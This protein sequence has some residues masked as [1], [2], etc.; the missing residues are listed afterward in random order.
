MLSEIFVR[1]V[2]EQNNVEV[3]SAKQLQEL[4]GIKE[5][6]GGDG[7]PE[8]TP[9]QRKEKATKQMEDLF[10][11]AMSYRYD[12]ALEEILQAGGNYRQLLGLKPEY[13]NLPE[14]REIRWEYNTYKSQYDSILRALDNAFNIGE[15]NT[16]VRPDLKAIAKEIE[17]PYSVLMD[18]HKK[19]NNWKL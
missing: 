15:P 2:E 16:S 17:A 10:I 9:K 3:T 14:H 4:T 13:F 12:N 19:Y 1:L 11:E 5:L 8:L 7:E 18:A 6:W